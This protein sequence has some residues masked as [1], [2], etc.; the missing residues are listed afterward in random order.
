MNIIGNKSGVRLIYVGVGLAVAGGFSNQV[1]AL[2]FGHVTNFLFFWVPVI[3][4][5]F[6]VTNLA[7]IMIVGGLIIIFVVAPFWRRLSLEMALIEREE[8]ETRSQSG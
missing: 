1:E 3:G 8:N 5:S 7:D 4:P 6:V 2:V